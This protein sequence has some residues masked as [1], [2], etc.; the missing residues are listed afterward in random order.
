[1]SQGGA[2]GRV[3][4][5][6]GSYINNRSNNTTTNF[7]PMSTEVNLNATYKPDAS[8]GATIGAMAGAAIAINRQ[9]TQSMTQS[10]IDQNQARQNPSAAMGGNQ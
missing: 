5:P 4:A 9:N 8:V 2:S 10:L 3:A 1:M 6:S 7:G